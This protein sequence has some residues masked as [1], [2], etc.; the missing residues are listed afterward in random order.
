VNFVGNSVQVVGMGILESDPLAP[1]LPNGQPSGEYAM[2]PAGKVLPPVDELMIV[3]GSTYV[4]WNNL[5]GAGT[6][7]MALDQNN[8]AVPPI[9]GTVKYADFD[10]IL[11]GEAVVTA[12]DPKKKKH[13]IW[14]L[15]GGLFLL[16]R[17]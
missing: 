4:V 9:P 8:K 15:L 16:S 7:V 12:P 2:I 13:W 1:P 10:W 14:L 5:F 6:Y 11:Q 3:D 17:K